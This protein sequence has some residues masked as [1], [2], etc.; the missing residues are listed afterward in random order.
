VG[1]VGVAVVLLTIAR[2]YRIFA[3]V[4]VETIAAETQVAIDFIDARAVVLTRIRVALI[5]FDL[6]VVAFPPK[7]ALA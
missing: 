3:V 6:A 7:S 5:N 2:Q 4:P 1:K